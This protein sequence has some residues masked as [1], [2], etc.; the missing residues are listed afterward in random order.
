MRHDVH[1]AAATVPMHSIVEPSPRSVGIYVHWPYCKSKCTYCDFNRY[2]RE[3]V[4]HAR[5]RRCLTTEL[6]SVLDEC[7]IAR[8]V[9]AAGV[10]SDSSTAHLLVRRPADCLGS[11][12]LWP[13]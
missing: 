9:H 3:S 1:N 4:D 5:M 6:G 2:I 8:C 10:S 7:D 12:L 13:G 11:E